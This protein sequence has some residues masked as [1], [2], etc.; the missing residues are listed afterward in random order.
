MNIIGVKID[1]R[2]DDSRCFGIQGFTMDNQLALIK[3]IAKPDAGCRDCEIG[4]FFPKNSGHL[5]AI[6]L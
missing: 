1:D 5:L 4:I 6:F 2:V 3:R